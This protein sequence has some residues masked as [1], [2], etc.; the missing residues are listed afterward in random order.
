MANN[1]LLFTASGEVPHGPITAH[2]RGPTMANNWHA[3]AHMRGP[4]K[5]NNWC[6]TAPPRGPTKANNWLSTALIARSHQGK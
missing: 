6:F 1:W 4:T 2:M 3:T 5:A